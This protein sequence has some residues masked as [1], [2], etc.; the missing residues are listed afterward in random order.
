MALHY[1]TVILLASAHFNT[2]VHY[3]ACL[4]DGSQVQALRD[5]QV[6]LHFV[7]EARWGCSLAQGWQLRVLVKLPGQLLSAG[8]A[9]SCFRC[10]EVRSPWQNLSLP[11]RLAARSLVP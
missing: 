3:C 10:L 1:W 7:C 9:A 4:H 6:Y 8:L 11:Q 2:L 5:G